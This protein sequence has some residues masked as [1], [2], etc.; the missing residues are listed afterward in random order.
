MSCKYII[1]QNSNIKE[2]RYYKIDDLNEDIH[3]ELK[4]LQHN[5]NEYIL[6]GYEPISNHVIITNININTTYYHVSQAMI[7]RN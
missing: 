6:K 1:V 4:E 2:L 7:K 5:I 3:D